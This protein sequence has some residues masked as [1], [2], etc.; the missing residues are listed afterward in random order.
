M[1]QDAGTDPVQAAQAF[2]TE[3]VPDTDAALQGAMDILAEEMANDADLRK[4]MRRLVMLTGTIQSHAVDADAETPYQNYYDYAEP[5]KRI[6]GHR[7]LA[8]DRGE[9][10]GATESGSHAAG[11]TRGIH[12]DPEVCEEPE[13]LRKAGADCRRGCVSAAAVPGGGAGDPQGADRTGGNGC[14]RCVCDQPA[15]AASWRH[16]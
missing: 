12:A 10:E 13:S 8:I 5:V 6:V 7:V 9:R 11:G 4:Q 16:R 1:A 3:E 15:A 2:L 14:H